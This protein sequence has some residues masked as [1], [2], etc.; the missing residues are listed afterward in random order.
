MEV[1][2]ELEHIEIF[3]Q[4]SIEVLNKKGRLAVVTFHSGEDRI[5]KMIFQQNTMGCIC[6][7]EFPICRCQQIPKIRIITKKPIIAN[8]KEIKI[9]PRARSAK[10]RIIE[11][12]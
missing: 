9:N 8:E 1:N 5:A 4:Q 10:L 6:P 12:I 2:R 11:K 7:K 3:L